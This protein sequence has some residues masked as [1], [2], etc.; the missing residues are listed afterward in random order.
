MWSDDLIK[1]FTEAEHDR[2]EVRR[3]NADA[4]ELRDR[5][6][7]AAEPVVKQA[8]AERF[9]YQRAAVASGLRQPQ[10]RSADSTAAGRQNVAEAKRRCK[11]A[12][13]AN[14]VHACA[15]CPSPDGTRAFKAHVAR[16]RRHR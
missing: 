1:S 13:A 2:A 6:R 3:I 8:K 9:L 15:H 5:A 7:R 16:S 11:N 14:D 4:A 12:N 10:R